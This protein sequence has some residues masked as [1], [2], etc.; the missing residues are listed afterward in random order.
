M[1]I[2]R[3]LLEPSHHTIKAPVLHHKHND[4]FD[5]GRS[6][7]LYLCEISDTHSIEYTKQYVEWRA[8]KMYMLAIKV[9]IF[10][11]LPDPSR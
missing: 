2:K 3:Y 6:A 7:V 5:L 10:T 8:F 9:Q 1:S 11:H 4:I